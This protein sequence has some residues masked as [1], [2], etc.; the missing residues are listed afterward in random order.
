MGGCNTARHLRTDPRQLQGHTFDLAVIGGGIQGAAFAREAAL[1]G[2]RV[3]LVEAGDFGSGTSSRSSRL[4]HGGLR[5]LRQGRLSLVRE[6]LRERERLL[7]L[8]PHLV[9]PLPMLLPFFRGGG[10]PWLQRFGVHAY[11]TLAG[12]ST[13]PRPRAFT[14]Q[15]CVM[16]F[17]ELRQRDL[18]SGLQFF[19]AATEDAR[20]TLANVEAAAESGALVCNHCKAADHK[21]GA[22]LLF[23]GISGD[24]VSV[25]A[26]VIVNATGPGVD[27]LRRALAIGD[28]PLLRIS[29]G[30]HLVLPP[31]PGECALAAFLPDRRI[32]FVIPHRDGT[33]C[34]TTEFDDEADEEQPAV[35][36]ADVDYL[37]QALGQLLDPAPSRADAVYAYAGW[38]ALPATKGPAGAVDREAFL[39]HERL[40]QSQLYNVV[41]GKL[42]THRSFA[43]RSVQQILGTSGPSPS[44]SR[45]LPGGG[46]PRDVRDPLWWRHG[47]VAAQLHAQVER[48]RELGEPICPHRPFLAVEAAH[49]LRRQA[50]VTFAD[51]MLRRLVHS[52]GPCLREACL[53]RAHEL[54][55]QHRQWPLD[56]GTRAALAALRAEVRHLTGGIVGGDP[57]PTLLSDDD[58]A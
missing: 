6:A 22:L 53:R 31:R 49:A 30:A 26:R 19:D 18:L 23:D 15:Q 16:A 1:R 41:G 5:Y 45:P 29:R 9:R 11:A 58:P 44:R 7:R 13:M 25:H 51:L 12:R 20:L 2:A 17:P 56:D 36:A 40:G 55:L 24:A 21:N 8:A 33:L 50:A 54:F 3:L 46:G 52:Q 47:S 37:L 4:I 38:R 32:Q 27:I 34:G 39:V 42:T 43:E 28:R 35:A 57:I 10:R 14:A 48:Q